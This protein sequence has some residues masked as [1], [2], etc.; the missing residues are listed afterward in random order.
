MNNEK[1]RRIA[2]TT[3]LIMLIAGFCVIMLG[4]MEL[5]GYEMISKD[6]YLTDPSTPYNEME[7]ASFTIPASEIVAGTDAI[8]IWIVCGV[9]II[10]CAYLSLLGFALVVPTKKKDHIAN[11]EYKVVSEMK[12]EYCPICG[13]RL[14]DVK[15]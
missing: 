14:K 8:F 6:E 5:H 1:K 2:G 13:I 15:Q 11:C 7:N 3:F 9:S 10:G 12:D 4:A